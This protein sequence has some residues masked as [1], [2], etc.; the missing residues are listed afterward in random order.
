MFRG[1]FKDDS[2][3]LHEYLKEVQCVFQGSFK[4]S[5][6]FKGCLNKVFQE[7]FNNIFFTIWLWHGSHRTYP[8]RKRAC[9]NINHVFNSQVYLSFITT[10]YNL[11]TLI[12]SK[13]W[14]ALKQLNWITHYI[15]QLNRTV[16]LITLISSRSNYSSI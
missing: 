13:G 4:D 15:K 16:Y 9:L 11:S 14:F 3:E 12:C 10:P 2:R 5:R 6:R 7:C 1:T 8:S